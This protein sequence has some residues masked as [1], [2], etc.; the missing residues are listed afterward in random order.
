MVRRC[1]AA[2]EEMRAEGLARTRALEGLAPNRC[3]LS[4][5]TMA[6][7]GG[8][9]HG[10][11]ATSGPCARSGTGTTGRTQQLPRAIGHAGTSR[12]LAPLPVMRSTARFARRV[13]RS[14]PARVKCAGND[15]L[16]TT[17]SSRR[18]KAVA[19]VQ[20]LT[21]RRTWGTRCRHRMRSARLAPGFGSTPAWT[22]LR[23]VEKPTRTMK[24]L[25]GA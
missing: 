22:M 1:A 14:T 6:G 7:S 24:C 21:R 3:A 19:H 15:H 4:H 8:G 16:A 12:V 20:L 18:G 5:W 9:R 23:M 2:A 10:R 13:H 17:A 11:R 25:C